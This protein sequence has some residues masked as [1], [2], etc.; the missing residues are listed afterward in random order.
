MSKTIISTLLILILLYAAVYDFKKREIPNV[1]VILLF[2]V[3]AAKVI[4]NRSYSNVIVFVIY[5]LFFLAIYIFVEKKGIYLLGEGDIKLLS[6]LSLYFGLDFLKV[7]ILTCI[8][9]FAAGI[10][11]GIVKKTYLKTCIPLAPFVLVASILIEVV[12]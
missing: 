8:S 12:R 7:L 3:S 11:T 6:V 2:F 1:A 10:V 4:L 5:T 9:G